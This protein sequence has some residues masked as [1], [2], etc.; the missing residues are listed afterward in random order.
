MRPRARRTIAL[1]SLA[2]PLVA[3]AQAATADVTLYMMEVPPLTVNAVDRRGPAGDITMEAIRRAGY[4]P[5]LKVVPSNRA[6]RQVQLTTSRDE[7]II[8][9]ARQQEREP[10]YTW[11]APVAKVHRAFFSM[12]RRVRS[13]GEARTAFRTIAVARGT[14]GLN[15]LHEQGFPD[16]QLVEVVDG[17]AAAKML[18][19]GRVDAWY[20]PELQFRQWQ[21]ETDPQGRVQKGARLGST[22]NY[23]ACSRSCDPVLVA[24]LGEA[25]EKMRRDGSIK[26][27]EARYAGGE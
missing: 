5:D 23:L 11:I 24:R 4:R 9:L 3:K 19:I 25:L 14:A 15:I 10:H 26:A 2:L 17:I 13:F 27:I 22:E 6:M 8:P 12:T 21:R 1:L 18:M 16:A 7:L 20:G